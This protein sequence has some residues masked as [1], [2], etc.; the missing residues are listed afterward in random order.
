MRKEAWVSMCAK[1]VVVMCLMALF[2]CGGC[3]RGAG[4]KAARNT[5][6]PRALVTPRGRVYRSDRV[7]KSVELFVEATLPEELTVYQNGQ[8]P[9]SIDS[10]VGS[11]E[12]LNRAADEKTIAAWAK[13]LPFGPAYFRGTVRDDPDESFIMVAYIVTSGVASWNVH[14]FRSGR[15]SE[16][17]ATTMISGL[18]FRDPGTNISSAEM[19][20]SNTLTLRDKRNDELVRFKL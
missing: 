12:L 4:G 6:K 3:H 15:G 13:H 7:P 20:D 9:E 8:I 1:Q 14:L 2:V 17:R 16:W 10:C 19:P 18:L 5:Q 11:I